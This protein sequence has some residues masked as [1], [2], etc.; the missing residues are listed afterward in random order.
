[1]LGVNFAIYYFLDYK[2]NIIYYKIRFNL[3]KKKRERNN[4]QS[5]TNIKIIIISLS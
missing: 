5:K 4:V 2:L 1:M 3:P